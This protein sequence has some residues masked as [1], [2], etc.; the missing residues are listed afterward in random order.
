MD[1]HFELNTINMWI[2]HILKCQTLLTDTSGK[3]S[4]SGL[5]YF[6]NIIIIEAQ[7]KLYILHVSLRNI[8]S[9]GT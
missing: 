5:H 3:V 9:F 1:G 7:T 4:Y 8:Y 2:A 6:T